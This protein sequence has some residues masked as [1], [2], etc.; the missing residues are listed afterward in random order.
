M[1]YTIVSRSFSFIMTLESLEVR[2][3]W[4]SS[5]FPT[6]LSSMI[7]TVEHIIAFP[8]VDQAENVNVVGSK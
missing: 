3:I 6:M 5:V 2:Y 1:M 8:G 7:K 4:N